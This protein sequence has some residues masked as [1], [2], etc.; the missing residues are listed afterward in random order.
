MFFLSVAGLYL[1]ARSTLAINFPYESIQL[2]QSETANNSDVAFGNEANTEKPPCKTFPGYEGWPSVE[3]WRAFNTT[4]GGSLIRGVPPAA[5]CY[6]GE[7][8][9]A[10]RCTTV[11]RGFN[12]ALFA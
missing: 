4:L 6:D 9:D 1:F 10:A 3:R 8:R 7:F 2:Q 11:R 5:A 12:D